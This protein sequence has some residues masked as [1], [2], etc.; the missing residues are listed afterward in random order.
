MKR[1]VSTAN[2]MESAQPVQM[3][4]GVNPNWWSIRPP[5]VTTITSSYQQQHHL[6]NNPLPPNYNT[7]LPF[8][9]PKSI[10]LSPYPPQ[11]TSSS[12]TSSWLEHDSHQKQ[13][14][15]DHHQQLPS[16]TWSHDTLGGRQ[17][18][19]ATAALTQQYQ[20]AA[21][22]IK[23][24]NWE[25]THDSTS[26]VDIKQEHHS[27]QS[28]CYNMFSHENEELLDARLTTAAWSSAP[29]PDSSPSKSC[30]TSFG[31]HNNNMLDFS[32]N[33]GNGIIRNP[34]PDC[35]SES[36][37][38]AAA[39][40]SKKARVQQS[41]PQSNTLKV[42]K[43]KL[44]DRIT[45]LHQ[46]VSPFGKTDTA[47]VL[48][49]AMGYIRFLQSQI[50]ALS[51]PYLGSGSDESRKQHQQQ[52]YMNGQGERSCL[53]PE[54]P[55][56]LLNDNYCT[57]RKAS[58]DLQESSSAEKAGP[59]KDLRSRGL[60]LVPVSCTLLQVGTVSDINGAD[61]WVPPPPAFFGGAG[62]H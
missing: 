29:I 30:V 49:E 22:N 27:V 48:F 15:Q 19:A 46:L 11:P 59:K 62:F 16:E 61:Y 2:V 31:N 20:M 3:G 24:Q 39:G 36:N 47:S 43:E 17:Q 58:S 38:C 53:F 32:S 51:L 60:C 6:P 54:D 42:R 55:G 21:N 28:G 4:G 57:K 1:R 5:P 37:S 23:F 33:N 26:T 41:P 40:A 13:L 52:Q 8:G 12:N 25:Q 35:P 50:E 34:T 9:P 45:V 7:F 10:I 56:Q 18:S 44:G 14:Q